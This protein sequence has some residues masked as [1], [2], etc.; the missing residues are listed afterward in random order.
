LAKSG[1]VDPVVPAPG[2]CQHNPQDHALGRRPSEADRVPH[3]EELDSVATNVGAQMRVPHRHLDRAMAQ[4]LLDAFDGRPAHDQVRGEGMARRVPSD[5]PEASV[6]QRT[7]ERPSRLGMG[8]HGPIRR[9][10]DKRP[11]PGMVPERVERLF[12][13][14]NLTRPSVF[15]R[16][17]HAF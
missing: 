16:V 3:V 14:R 6:L 10:E 12:A 7:L 1:A 4:E 13:Q 2:L 11:L 8:E 17:D 9:A 5:V 15:R